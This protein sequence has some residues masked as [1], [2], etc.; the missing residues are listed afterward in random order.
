MSYRFSSDD[1]HHLPGVLS[2]P[3]FATYL[4][5]TGHDRRLA[6]ELYAWNL[7]ISSALLVPLH[8]YEV[9]IRN[10]IA[11]GIDSVHGG[12]W[13]WTEGF[14]I[15]LPDPRPPHYSPKRDLAT[16]AG[17]QPTT[18]KVIA[19]L[20]FAFWESM[21]TRRHQARLW[22]SQFFAVFPDAP[23]ED[24]IDPR[25]AELRGDMEIIRGLRNRIA[26]HE[27]VF[28]RDLQ[29]DLARLTKGV[30]WRNQTA[31]RWLSSIEAASA[32]LACR[33]ATSNPGA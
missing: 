16:C 12:A 23:R 31:Q 26:H 25:R 2:A 5:A 28:M 19:E 15:S 11:D 1:L 33:P 18:G 9:A 6:L 10:A 24:G 14:M 20:K 17:V 27:P 21:L 13:P 30:A 8:V 32:L 22:D 7:E 3:R 4:Q 29:A